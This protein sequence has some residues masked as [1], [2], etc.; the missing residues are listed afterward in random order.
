MIR[1]GWLAAVCLAAC[2]ATGCGE[3]AGRSR[4]LGTVS[5]E[6]AFA[7]ATDVMSQYFSIENADPA[8]G[9]IT[10]RPK[11]VRAGNE[12]LLGGSPARQVARMRLR[13]EG[14][15]V[16][17]SLAVA[18]QR[19]GEAVH[20]QRGPAGETYSSVPNQT[21]AEVE[22]ATTPLQNESWRTERYDRVMEQQILGQLYRTLH[23][24]A[25]K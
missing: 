13:R 6:S 16:T 23:P 4:L 25:E 10:S 2:L 14:G 19:Q 5:Y 7:A 15:E 21:P 11:A 1:Q 24:E 20:L 17:A 3:P 8:T 18:V 22:A 12:R 9:E